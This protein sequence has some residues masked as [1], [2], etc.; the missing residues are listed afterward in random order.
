MVFIN[1][2]ADGLSSNIKSFADNTSLFS[3]IH[4]VDTSAN[5][6]HNQLYIVNKWA[7]QWKMSFDPDQNKQAQE[8]IFSRTTKKNSNPL[9]HFS[10][11]IVLQTPYQ[12]HLAMFL[13]L[14]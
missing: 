5:K 3:L 8:N 12:K 7:F 11:S 4:N 13:L 6:L 1:D 2:L 14:N 9:L 10:N